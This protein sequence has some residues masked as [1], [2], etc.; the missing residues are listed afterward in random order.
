[1]PEPKSTNKLFQI[2]VFPVDSPREGEIGDE[3]GEESAKLLDNVYTLPDTRQVRIERFKDESQLAEIMDLIGRELSEP[4]SIYTYRYFIHYWPDFCI[5]ARKPE[6]GAIVG[7]IVCKL[8][9]QKIENTCLNFGQG[10]IA[11]LAV[12]ESYR[13]MGLGTRL[14]RIAIWLMEQQDCDEVILETEVSNA[15]SLSLYGRIGFIR[16]LRLFRYYLNGSD[17]FRLKLYLDQAERHQTKSDD[18]A[19]HNAA[20]NEATANLIS[21]IINSGRRNDGMIGANNTE[22]TTSRYVER[23]EANEKDEAVDEIDKK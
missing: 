1:M 21:A 7:V 5:L 18:T 17:A 19:K 14:V 8:E 12:E 10:Y 11:M 6:T 9:H 20:R 3:F 4:Y 15:R 22:T 2:D 23:D 16:E 13:G